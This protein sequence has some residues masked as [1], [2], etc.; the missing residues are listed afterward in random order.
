MASALDL[1][2]KPSMLAPMYMVLGMLL[3]PL[4]DGTAKLLVADYSV[5]QVVWGRYFFHL[6]SLFPLFFFFKVRIRLRPDDLSIQIARAIFLLADTALFFAALSFIPLTNGKAVFF[7]SPLIMTALAPL[8]LSEK[9][10]FHRWVAV[11]VGFSG[12]L[13]ILRPEADGEFLGYLLAFGSAAFYALYLLLTRKISGQTA[14]LNTLLFTAM[15]GTL[16]MTAILPLYWIT[17]D[18]LGLG[19]MVL[20][21]VLGTLS[22]FFIIKAFESGDA[23]SLAPFSYAE[24]VSAT[25]FGMIVFGHLPGPFTWIGIMIV[26]VSGL[27]VFHRERIKKPDHPAVT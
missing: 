22:H 27:Y 12:T 20:T 6:L 11:I 16:V 15:I 14:P 24:I 19:L 13:F 7:V 21:G 26:S 10:G 4:M 2:S 18:L 3:V 23:S 5:V 1:K 8:I 9:V 17:P 25:L